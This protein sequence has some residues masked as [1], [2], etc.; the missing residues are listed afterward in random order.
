MPRCEVE[1]TVRPDEATVEG[2]ARLVPGDGACPA[3][4]ACRL[5]VRLYPQRFSREPENYDERTAWWYYPGGFDAGGMELTSCR[6][7]SGAEC[8]PEPA[9][10][11]DAVWIEVPA[12]ESP[13]VRLGFRVRVPERFGGF[14]LVDD[15]LVLGGGWHPLLAARGGDGSPDPT[16]PLERAD[17]ALR[18]RVGP[19]WEL[20]VDGEG[21]FP[22][23]AGDEGGCLVERTAPA[24]EPPSLVAAPRWHERAVEAAGVR[25][26]LL[27][28]EP[29]RDP[30]S[31]AVR[32]GVGL[33]PGSVPDLWSVDRRGWMLR[34]LAGALETLDEEELLPPRE[35]RA[36]EV[37]LIE[38][39]MRL[40]LTLGV[41]GLVLVSDR[42]YKLFPIEPFF[43]F[44]DA[45]VQRAVVAELGRR[46]LAGLPPAEARWTA[47]AVAVGAV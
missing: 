11:P 22:C 15:V 37:T 45:D 12:G 36:A 35:R 31:F 25:V 21:P 41:S 17:Y 47:E 38:V 5:L 26:R 19:G 10:T 2:E 13:E 20:V 40:E 46:A 6:T 7:A 30:A 4:G 24:A 29:F 1:A 27:S 16:A 43:R 44:Q 9:E 8:A 34:Q 32:A 28:P 39:P 18:V 33:D 42:A 3:D 23:A 14:G